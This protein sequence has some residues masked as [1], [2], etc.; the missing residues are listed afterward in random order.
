MRTGFV[1][2][3]LILLFIFVGCGR[4]LKPPERVEFQTIEFRKFWGWIPSY[5]MVIHSTGETEIKVRTQGGTVTD[6]L[7]TVIRDEEIEALRIR[8]GDAD[9]FSLENY[10]EPE[11]FWKDQNTHRITVVRDG[12]EKLVQVYDYERIQKLPSGLRTLIEALEDMFESILG[13]DIRLSM[14]P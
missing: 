6:S 14:N 8:L 13:R 7:S 3:F 4:V 12:C 10:Y 1:R 2:T 11:D 5:R 9:F